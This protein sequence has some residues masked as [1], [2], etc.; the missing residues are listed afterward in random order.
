MKKYMDIIFNLLK[1]IYEVALL[2]AP[3][4]TWNSITRQ[5][6]T[7]SDAPHYIAVNFK[8]RNNHSSSFFL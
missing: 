2:V 8:L 3:P 1:K 6:T 5:N 7:I 4:P